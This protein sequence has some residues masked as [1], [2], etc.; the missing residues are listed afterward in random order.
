MDRLVAHRAAEVWGVHN[1]II[2]PALAKF[3]CEI[4]RKIGMHI[5]QNAQEAQEC[6]VINV[7]GEMENRSVV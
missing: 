5:G 3:N 2:Q 6:E 1:L 4:C 7:K